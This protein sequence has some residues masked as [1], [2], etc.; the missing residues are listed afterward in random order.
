MLAG[1][2]NK[3]D[4]TDPL[5]F[6]A[7]PGLLKPPELKRSTERNETLRFEL[8][9]LLRPHKLHLKQCQSSVTDPIEVCEHVSAACERFE[10]TC[11][12]GVFANPFIDHSTR[13]PL[14][15]TSHVLVAFTEGP[16]EVSPFSMEDLALC[17]RA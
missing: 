7:F 13:E 17:T 10:G 11:G 2:L 3:F 5:S 14:E 12:L 8:L 1:S 6:S 9:R 16:S 15:A 4:K